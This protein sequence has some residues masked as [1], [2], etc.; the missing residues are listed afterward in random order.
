VTDPII[1]TETWTG[2]DDA[3]WP[4][5][6]WPI[7]R[8]CF[9]TGSP[10]AT[11]WIEGNKGLMTA[12]TADN[13]TVAFTV[14]EL[15]N[16]DLTFTVNKPDIAQHDFT[17]VGY[18]IGTNITSGVPNTGYEFQV[19]H[20][21]TNLGI[22]VLPS[23]DAINGSGYIHGAAGLDDGTP[24]IWRLLVK[25][26][27]HR[28]K[29]WSVGDPEP[30]TWKIDITENTPAYTAPGRLYLGLINFGVGSTA[31]VE[32]DDFTLTEIL[33]PDPGIRVAASF[34]PIVALNVGVE[35]VVACY[36]GSTPIVVP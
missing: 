5:A 13:F 26:P 10:A 1:V 8:E 21:D 7:I 31:T 3:P 11:P 17:C 34:D 36:Q 20:F 9:S 23:H 12:G 14:P 29:W 2:A 4:S 27:R 32:W 16:F 35:P 15:Y 25:G 18:R 28:L 22:T 19:A 30:S 33:P 6:T 24:R